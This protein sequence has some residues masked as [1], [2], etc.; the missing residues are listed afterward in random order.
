M[1]GLLRLT[2][3]G[4][5]G[6]GDEETHLSKGR[7][8]HPIPTLR[9]GGGAGDCSTD[10]N[11]WEA[12]PRGEIVKKLAEWIKQH[13]VAAFFVLTFAI[14]WGLWIPLV[15]LVFGR[16]LYILLPL[17][18]AGVFGPALAGIILSAVVRPAPRLGRRKAR[19]LAFFLTCLVATTA[20]ALYWA[21]SQEG[22]SVSAGLV[23]IAAMSA[24]VP[25]FIVSSAFSR[26]P[27]VRD[28]LVSLVKPRGG[29]VWYLTAILLT[30]AMLSL[31]IVI[32]RISGIE[33]PAP[34]APAGEGLDLVGVVV[35]TAANRFFFGNA[36][37]EE[38]GW[39]GFALP[40][41]QAQY[42]PL[43]ANL[44]LAFFWFVW[45]LPLPQAQGLL[46]S[47]DPAAYLDA[48]WSFFLNSLILAWLFNH[49]K[50]SI[51]VAGLFHV[52]WNISIMFLPFPDA[53]DFIRPVFCVLI[54]AL[55]QMW[56][57]LPLDSAA[58]YQADYQAAYQC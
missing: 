32:A 24:L 23:A 41:L 31:G 14:S 56:R 5:F 33:M 28:Y 22:V 6:E 29:V 25:A 42:N 49:T 53:Y 35:L 38:V 48:Y 18:M 43:V 50:G 21:E 9:T 3:H 45:H 4:G 57:K 34:L 36:V 17:A 20:S 51:L 37:G 27:G 8:V 30:P 12:K 58:V 11:R 13:Q 52:S 44:I 55:D 26:V 15:P 40:R 16:G 10:R 1:E 47:S 7:R 2:A 19:W 46:T 39:R 54:I